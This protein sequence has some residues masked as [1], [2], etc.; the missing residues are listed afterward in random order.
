MRSLCLLV[1][2]L[3]VACAGPPTPEEVR[4]WRGE[5]PRGGAPGSLAS[6]DSARY[7]GG[8]EALRIARAAAVDLAEAEQS[9]GSLWRAARAEADLVEYLRVSEAPREGRDLA[10]ASGLVWAER[11][12][13]VAGEDP[14]GAL[15]GQLA[16]SLGSVT[17]L[18]PMFDRD[19]WAVRVQAACLRAL[20]VE[21][22]QLEAQ[23]TQ[24]TLHLR[25]ATLPWIAKLF[26]GDAPEA[27][28]A[29]AERRARACYEARPSLE[30]ALLLTK[31]L[32][33][34]DREPEAQA[35]ARKALL[36]PDRFPRDVALRPALQALLE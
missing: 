15:L 4:A 5:Q 28:L 35:L 9:P 30:H 7:A 3:F 13:E 20:A 22:T 32:T 6:V 11:A 36:R 27:D 24:A 1:P 18:Q 12:L 29:L 16:W 2:L 34:L 21:P 33:A 8:L 17:H 26:A 25:L 19:D 10:A 14:E 23:A 31:I